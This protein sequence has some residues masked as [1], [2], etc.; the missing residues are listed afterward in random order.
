MG[1][2]KLNINIL[3]ININ[4]VGVKNFLN[5]FISFEGDKYN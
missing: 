4:S 2:N 1:L 5:L 3:V